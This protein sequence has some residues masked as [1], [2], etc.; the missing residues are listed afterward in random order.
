M[1]IVD[2]GQYHVDYDELFHVAD[3]PDETHNLIREHPDI[4]DEL[5][6]KLN[7][8]RDSELG[9]EPDPVRVEMARGATM[10]DSRRDGLEHMG[11]TFDEWIRYYQ[12]RFCAPLQA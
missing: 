5:E 8:W 3:D 9:G 4:A 6:L 2:P 12:D 11:M 10:E 1:K 7:R